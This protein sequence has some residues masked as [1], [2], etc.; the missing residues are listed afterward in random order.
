MPNHHLHFDQHKKYMKQTKITE[1]STMHNIVY[2]SFNNKINH[3]KTMISYQQSSTDH[4][5]IRLLYLF[6]NKK[7]K[8]QINNSNIKSQDQIQ[9][10]LIIKI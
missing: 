3:L 10:K 6:Q 4:F 2:R 5:I 8:N 7:E 9:F 1:W